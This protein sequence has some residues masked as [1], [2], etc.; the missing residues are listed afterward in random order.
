MKP[1]D[2]QT[3]DQ[4][5]TPP[6]LPTSPEQLFEV[7]RNLKIEYRL[8][9]HE[10]IFTVA[11]G[12]HL[13]ENI[14]GLHCR[15]LFLRD[16]KKRMFLIV[17]A[18]ETAV[19]LKKAQNLL[20]CDRLSFGSTERLWQYLGIRPGSV[21]PFCVINDQEKDV[22]VILDKYMMS[23]D[24]VCYHPLDNAMTIGLTPEDLIKFIEY[25]GHKPRVVDL[26]PAAPE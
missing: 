3:S 8:Y 22:E 15:N 17:A 21:C 19:D 14:P 7:L 24:I 9:H 20:E 2:Q 13:K 23:A 25:T 12:E 10:P 16:K 6:E 18:N 11:E 26:S 4:A 1:Q 5:K